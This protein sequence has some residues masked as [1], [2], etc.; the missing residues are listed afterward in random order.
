LITSVDT[1]DDEG[2]SYEVFPLERGMQWAGDVP[3]HKG[4][5]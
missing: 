4:K 1:I 2:S 5:S 3:G